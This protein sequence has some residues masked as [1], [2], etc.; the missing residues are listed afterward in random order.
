M[1]VVYLGRDFSE[2]S[3]DGNMNLYAFVAQL[4]SSLTEPWAELLVAATR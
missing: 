2:F 1:W 4:G 3:G